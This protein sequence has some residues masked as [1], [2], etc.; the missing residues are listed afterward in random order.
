MVRYGRG[1]VRLLRKHP[2]TLS[3]PC[4]VPAAFVLG[5]VVGPVLAWLSPWLA[6]AYAGAL[7]LYALLVALACVTCTVQ[8]RDL[9]ILPWLPLVFVAIHTGAGCGFLQELVAGGRRRAAVGVE[10]QQRRRAA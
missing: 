5:L 2:E 10:L 9:R 3:L 8:A 7:G 6:F 4:L 1:R